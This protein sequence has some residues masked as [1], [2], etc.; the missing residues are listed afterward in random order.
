MSIE[1]IPEMTASCYSPELGKEFEPE[2]RAGEAAITAQESVL[3]VSDE[4]ADT[5]G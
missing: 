3:K 5:G 2:T 1:Q 4:L